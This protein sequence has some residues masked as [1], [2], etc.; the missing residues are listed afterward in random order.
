MDYALFGPRTTKPLIIIEA[1]SIRQGAIWQFLSADYHCKKDEDLKDRFTY[2]LRKDF[3]QL[4]D[5]DY[6]EKLYGLRGSD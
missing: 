1:E 4:R 2:W 5:Y 6:E 3:N